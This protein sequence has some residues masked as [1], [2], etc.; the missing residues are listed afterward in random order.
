MN[1][2][3]RDTSGCLLIAKKRSALRRLHEHLRNKSLHK[4]YL[5]LLVGSF[6]RRR[7]QLSAPLLKNELHN[8]ERISRVR[9]DG[10]EAKTLF[11]VIRYYQEATLVEATPLTGRTHQIRVHCQYLGHPI[12][13]DRKYGDV[14]HDR[15]VRAMG[16]RRMLLHAS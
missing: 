4:I 13:G 11:K 10:K 7:K 9:A 3:A 1:R 12:V 5:A 15:V 2:R 14:D 16:V 8:G 6:P